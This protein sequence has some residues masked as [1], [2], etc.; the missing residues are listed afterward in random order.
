M[1]LSQTASVGSPLGP[2]IVLPMD[3]DQLYNTRHE[4]LS[5]EQA[6]NPIKN[7]AACSINGL[8]TV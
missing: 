1:M 5:I 6:S 7:V 3:F 2:M 8:T 4:F